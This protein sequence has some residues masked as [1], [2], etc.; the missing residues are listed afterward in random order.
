[1]RVAKI[2][3]AVAFLLMTSTAMPVLAEDT[4][5]QAGD[6]QAHPEISMGDFIKADSSCIEFNDHC[7]FCKVTD[8]VAECSTPQIACIKQ[9]YQCTKSSGQ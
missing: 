5:Q 6:N 2:G 3:F 1:M 8:G 9:A 4:P 7:S